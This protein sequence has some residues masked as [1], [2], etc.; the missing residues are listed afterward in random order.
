MPEQLS[1]EEEL[2]RLREFLR[3]LQQ[4]LEAVVSHPHNILPGRHHD[5]MRDAWSE[6][7]PTFDVVV[8]NVTTNHRSQLEAAGLVG[9]KLVFELGVFSHARDELLDHAPEIFS[10]GPSR[11]QPEKDGGWWRRLR[12]LLRRC[13]RIGDVVLGSLAKIPTFKP[14]E[15]IKQFKE[16]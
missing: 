8:S 10:M 7:R 13:L 2:R 16:G 1:A 12:R 3:Q 15:I 11:Q 4:L 14:A 6:V 5:A 9:L